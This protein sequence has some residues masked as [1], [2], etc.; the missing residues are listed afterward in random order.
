MSQPTVYHGPWTPK[1][2]MAAWRVESGSERRWSRMSRKKASSLR[3]SAAELATSW[4]QRSR[5]SIGLIAWGCTSGPPA[6][7]SIATPSPKALSHT[8]AVATAGSAV[9]SL[10]EGH[11]A[12]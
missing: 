6:A 2:A 12:A 11:A 8:R 3:R 9:E 5:S 4:S 7:A 10:L 1:N